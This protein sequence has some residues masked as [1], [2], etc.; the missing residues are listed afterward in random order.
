MLLKDLMF[1]IDSNTSGEDVDILKATLRMAWKNMNL[2][3]CME[4]P[5]ITYLGTPTLVNMY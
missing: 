1:N 4:T 5:L 2:V 3:E